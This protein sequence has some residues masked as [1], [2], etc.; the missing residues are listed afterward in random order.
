MQS[1]EQ[2]GVTISFPN[3]EAEHQVARGLEAIRSGQDTPRS[4]TAAPLTLTIRLGKGRKT[5]LVRL[6]DAGGERYRDAQ[7]YK[8][9]SLNPPRK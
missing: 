4:S 1:A 3:P 6:F 9:L 8:D 2:A 5:Y 7:Q